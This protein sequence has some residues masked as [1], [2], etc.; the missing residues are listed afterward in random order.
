MYWL[1]SGKLG[2]TLW[3]LPAMREMLRLRHEEQGIV[4]LQQRYPFFDV[5][6]AL[7]ALRPLL[8][9]QSYISDVTLNCP[10]DAVDGNVWWLD[11]FRSGKLKSDGTWNLATLALRRFNL[12]D[13]CADSAWISVEPK[14]IAKYVISRCLQPSCWNASMLWPAILDRYGQES[15]FL[16]ARVEYEG[17]IGQFGRRVAY[18]RT[19][20]LREA[21][22]VIAGSDRIFCNQ[23]ALHT[24]AEAMKKDIVLEVSNDYPSVVFRRPGVVNVWDRFPE[25]ASR[26]GL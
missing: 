16:G 14:P 5:R 18:H 6:V 12:P 2:D 4:C 25:A 22:Q 23:S 15:V 1:H 9:Q 3:A 20:T 8:I 7:R 11:E 13:S 17:F 24:I 10:A 26:I 21:A 19:E